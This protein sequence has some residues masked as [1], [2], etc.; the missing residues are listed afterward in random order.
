M[1]KAWKEEEAWYERL[2]LDIFDPYYQINTD[3]LSLS[4]KA[5]AKYEGKAGVKYEGRLGP[6]I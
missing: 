2:R 5:G 6:A 4:R 1:P 3:I